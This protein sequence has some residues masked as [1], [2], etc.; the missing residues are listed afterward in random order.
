MAMW[1]RL[2]AVAACVGVSGV[3]HAATEGLAVEQGLTVY[4][5][6]LYSPSRPLTPYRL[7]DIETVGVSWDC[8]AGSCVMT[9][10]ARLNLI[11]S[12]VDGPRPFQTNN[13]GVP[14]GG[15][16][17]LIANLRAPG[18]QVQ[19]PLG[20]AWE[21]LPN[22]EDWRFGIHINEH[23]RSPDVQFTVANGLVSLSVYGLS[24]AITSGVT[25]W[26]ELGGTVIDVTVPG[27]LA[28]DG[29]STDYLWS[30]TRPPSVTAPVYALPS[31]DPMCMS[32]D[33]MR[34]ERGTL[35][36]DAY[37]VSVGL[38]AVPVPVPEPATW[39]SMGLGLLALGAVARRRRA[40]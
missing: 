31:L 26:V 25:G 17:L 22:G 20:Q 2:A 28:E 15:S 30:F 18:L 7:L 5:D 19:D 9:S 38:S 14:A 1:K 40:H 16:F 33:C 23:V 27:G 10:D 34:Y 8:S 12:S 13:V 21:L 39:A 32:T 29:Q 3:A 36:I 35:M 24:A 37:R 11:M 4:L 6:V